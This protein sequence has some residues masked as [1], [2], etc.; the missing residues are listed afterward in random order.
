M[1]QR[2]KVLC[3]IIL[4]TIPTIQFGGYF[5]LSVLSG[6][7]GE[8]SLTP[9]QEAMFRAGHGHAGV[10]II[11]SL[12]AIILSDHAKLSPPFMQVV[13]V[14]FPLSAVLISGGFFA[15]AMGDQLETPNYWIFM[16]YIGVF[17]LAISLLTLGIGLLRDTRVG[18]PME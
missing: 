14:G 6:T 12:I 17:L 10:L 13:R 16:L 8:L 4:L 9:F 1:S 3:G 2:S 18:N 11:L 7:A 5:L 15:S